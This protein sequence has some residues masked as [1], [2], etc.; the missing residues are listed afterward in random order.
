MINKLSGLILFCMV[1][2]SV[3]AAPHIQT[4]QRVTKRSECT[5][6]DYDDLNTCLDDVEGES[7]KLDHASTQ[8][9]TWM[10]CKQGCKAL[11]AL[12]L[13]KLRALYYICAGKKRP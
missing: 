3:I 1:Q 9:T 11:Y 5:Y 6:F 2:C 10:A 4:E 8:W 7:E 13:S 12:V